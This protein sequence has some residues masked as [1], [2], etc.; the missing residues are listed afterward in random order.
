MRLDHTCTFFITR[1]DMHACRK[2]ILIAAIKLSISNYNKKKKLK[3][4]NYGLTKQGHSVSCGLTSVA[5]GVLVCY[6]VLTVIG[7]SIIS[8]FGNVI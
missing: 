2:K 8:V 4:A 6:L 3:H 7:T 5:Q 1:L